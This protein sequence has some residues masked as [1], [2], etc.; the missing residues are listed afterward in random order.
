M[1][2]EGGE[3]C[4]GRGAA[5]H[6]GQHPDQGSPP[7]VHTQGAIHI[8]LSNIYW[9]LLTRISSFMSLILPCFLHSTTE[10]SCRYNLLN[11]RK[12]LILRGFA[13]YLS[14]MTPAISY[15]KITVIALIL[16]TSPAFSNVPIPLRC[17]G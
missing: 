14:V 6:P 15:V 12:S 7:P 5:P 4:E 3:A 2:G 13:A 9:M 1:R 17:V 11:R 16:Q 10:S 8:S